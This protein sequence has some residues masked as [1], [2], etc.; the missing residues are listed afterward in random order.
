[1]NLT[2]DDAA[3]IR[4]LLAGEDLDFAERVTLTERLNTEAPPL[5][6]HV[7]QL[8]CALEGE[9]AKEVRAVA[10]KRAEIAE[11]A[12]VKRLPKCVGPQRPEALRAVTLNEYNGLDPW[13]KEELRK[14]FDAAI[15]SLKATYPQW[16]C[17]SVDVEH[18][19]PDVFLACRKCKKDG[20][21]KGV[22]AKTQNGVEKLVKCPVCKGEKKLP[23]PPTI[24]RSG[25]RRRVVVVTR[26]SRSRPD[27]LSVDIIGGKIPIDRLV[28]AGVLRGDTDEWL[29]RYPMWKSA[30]AGEGSVTIDVYEI[31]D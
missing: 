23:A 9:V 26:A 13:R 25:G 6:A 5:G 30:K 20:E 31:A 21:S 27:E 1:M 16:S 3:A 2:P 12:G 7:F 10:K 4:K 18:P 14:T 24:S 11:Q 19:R 15:E 22:V 28:V 8:V 29:A 17:G